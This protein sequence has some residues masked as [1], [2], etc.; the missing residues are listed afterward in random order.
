MPKNLYGNFFIR[1]KLQIE[2][3]CENLRWYLAYLKCWKY[4]VVHI[5]HKHRVVN[6]V[7]LASPFRLKRTFLLILTPEIWSRP[8][9]SMIL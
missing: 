5:V 2:H 6:R 9:F 3:Q 8:S 1:Y 7:I 4:M